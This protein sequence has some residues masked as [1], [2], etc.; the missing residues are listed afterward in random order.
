MRPIPDNVVVC[1]SKNPVTLVGE[2]GSMRG[3]ARIQNKREKLVVIHRGTLRFA[4]HGHAGKE[5]G[6]EIDCPATLMAMVPPG[7]SIDAPI[8]AS[9]PS[10][11]PP[12]EYRG[13]LVL[14]ASHYPARLLVAESF[15]TEITPSQIMV[16]RTAGRARKRIFV[17]NHGNVPVTVGTFG[18]IPLDDE[19]AVCRIIRATLKH[20]PETIRTIDEWA[21]RYLHEAGRHLEH[22]GMIWVDTEGDPVV[23]GPGETLPVDL[24]IRIPDELAPASRYTGIAK[25]YNTNLEITIVPTGDADDAKD[26]TA[27]PS[28]GTRV[29]RPK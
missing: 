8:Q 7:Q 17:S 20:P 19:L 5:H 28:G 25:W 16:A 3:T 9:I 15:D 2:P 6:G 1:D 22:L 21:T 12:G 4:L 14:G 11:V 26:S 27:A 23:V 18:A 13:L 29:R 24:T 10:S